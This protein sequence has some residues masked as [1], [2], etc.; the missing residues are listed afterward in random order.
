MGRWGQG[1]KGANKAFFG[2]LGRNCCGNCEETPY[3]LSKSATVR[4]V[5][6]TQQPR[7]AP[8]RNFATR[9]AE[10]KE[11]SIRLEFKNEKWELFAEKFG[12]EEFQD[13]PA[14]HP[15]PTLGNPKK[16]EGRLNASA[17]FG[18]LGNPYVPSKSAHSRP[19]FTAVRS[20]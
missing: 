9:G 7:G 13:G 16:V 14:Q 10:K 11:S 19:I 6:R 12:R 17:N 2:C 5:L 4:F 1:G 15:P 3:K 18:F 8:A 20:C